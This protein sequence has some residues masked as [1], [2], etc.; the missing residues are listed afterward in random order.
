MSSANRVIGPGG[1]ELT[2]PL[3]ASLLIQLWNI[4]SPWP[5][6]DRDNPADR[7][8]GMPYLVGVSAV[9]IGPCALATAWTKLSVLNVAPSTSISITWYL[10]LSE[11]L[12]RPLAISGWAERGAGSQEADVVIVTGCTFVVLAAPS[13]GCQWGLTETPTVWAKPAGRGTSRSMTKPNSRR[14]AGWR[15]SSEN[16]LWKSNF[17]TT[18]FGRTA[19]TSWAARPGGGG[20]GVRKTVASPSAVGRF[21]VSPTGVG[22]DSGRVSSTCCV[23]L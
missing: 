8:A 22:P 14:R 10:P 6:F 3:N 18:G 23:R 11:S 20:A 1:D 2:A 16:A 12:N 7:S 9:R 21:W 13:F 4:E 19:G 5:I 17:G 15:C